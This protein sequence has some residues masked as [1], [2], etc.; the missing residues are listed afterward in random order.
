MADLASTTVSF[1]A[2]ITDA[3]GNPAPTTEFR[4]NLRAYNSGGWADRLDVVQNLSTG[5]GWTH[6]EAVL[7]EGGNVAAQISGSY[8]SETFHNARNFTAH[9]I[10]SHFK[11]DARVSWADDEDTWSVVA[12]VSNLTDSDH[13]LIGFDVSGFYGNSQISYAKPRTYGVVV[14]RNF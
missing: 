3:A 4:F 7:S 8:Q 9:E 14:K 11:A 13:G 5:A 10:E 12:Y 2:L 1:D 6:V